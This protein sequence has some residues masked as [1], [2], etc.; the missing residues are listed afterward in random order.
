[1]KQ[2][3]NITLTLFFTKRIG[4]KTWENMG[5]LDRELALYKKLLLHLKVNMVTYGGSKDKAY[6]RAIDPIKILAV[7]W[8]NPAFITIFQLFL[9]YYPEIKNSNILKTN[10]ILGSEIPVWFK[11]KFKKK[12]IVRCGYLHSRHAI[13]RRKNAD[14]IRHAI[15]IEKQAFNEAD[16]ATVT[17]SWQRDLVIK[18]Y[19]LDSEKIKVIPNYILTDVFKP[20]FRVQKKYD[21]V[22]VGRGSHQKNIKNLLHAIKYL[23]SIKRHVSLVMVGDCCFNMRIKQ[24]IDEYALDVVFKGNVPN[25]ELPK[26][27]NQARVYILPSYFEGHPKTLLEAMSCGL[28]CIGSDITGI[29][30]DIQHLVTGYLCMTDFKSIA[31]AI[32][33]LLSDESLQRK[34]GKNARNYIIENYSLD[35][36]LQLELNVIKNVLTL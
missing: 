27:L 22:F 30:E 25:F 2:M 28:P 1:M 10:Q 35:K 14:F 32:V 9:K 29:K 18:S 16:I 24:M 7:K 31:E 20:D 33:T 11:K 19:E 15:H 17:S 12:L 36:I 26:I 3:D 34:L 4:L 13:K 23:K 6:A 8:R 21:L 5:I